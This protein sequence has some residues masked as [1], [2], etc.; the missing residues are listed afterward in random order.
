MEF[1]QLRQKDSAAPLC[2]PP[3]RTSSRRSSSAIVGTPSRPISRSISSRKMSSARLAPSLPG[4]GHPVERGAADEHRVGAEHHR[5]QDVG[6]APEAAIDDQRDPVADGAARLGQ[7][8]DRRHRPVELAPAMVRDRD[9]IGADLGG[10]LDI[11]HRQQSLDDQLAR[12]AVAD[13]RN[14]V[15]GQPAIHLRAD[16]MRA[17]RAGHDA[18]SG[19]TRSRSRSAADRASARARS[20]SADA[21]ADRAGRSRTGASGLDCRRLAHSRLP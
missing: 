11:A 13:P 20:A 21:A 2:Q 16:P 9:R 6:A 19:R 15:P 12:P 14:R 5:L 10:A 7:D 4:G 17:L 1:G 3:T 18:V 8:V